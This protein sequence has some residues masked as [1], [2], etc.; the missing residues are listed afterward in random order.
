MH[1]ERGIGKDIESTRKKKRRYCN[2]I[3]YSKNKNKMAK[4]ILMCVA[5][6]NLQH[7]HFLL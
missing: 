2:Y 5:T 3:T 6:A 4:E 1:I 7:N